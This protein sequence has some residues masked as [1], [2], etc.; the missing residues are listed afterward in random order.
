MSRS[1]QVA[2]A[3]F[4]VFRRRSGRGD[5]LRL[6][7][8]QLG[9]AW[10]KFGQ[11]L[12][13]RYDL[14]PAD[15][16][17]ALRPLQGKIAGEVGLDIRTVL[18]EKLTAAFLSIAE[19]PVAAA[20]IGQVHRAQLSDGTA[21]AV[22]VLRPS[23]GPLYAIDLQLLGRV[24]A[25]VDRITP[26]FHL[27]DMAREMST[28]VAEELDLRYEAD[29]MRR[30]RPVLKEHGLRVPKVYRGL[31]SSQVLVSQWIDG[32][33]MSDV[34]AIEDPEAWLRSQG[35]SGKKIG[36]KLL[37][38]MN[39]QIFEGNRFHGDPHPGNLM[40]WKGRIYLIDFGATSTTERA[41][42]DTFTGFVRALA[43]RDH[44]RA[45]DQYCLLC[46]WPTAPA[47]AA[48]AD[49]AQ[50]CLRRELIRVMAAWTSRAEIAALPFEDKSINRLT[51]ELMR[52]IFAAGGQ[53]NAGWL[54]ITRAMS[55]M[56]ATLGKLWPEVNYPKELRRYLRKAAAREPL[57][58]IHVASLVNTVTRLLDRAD[59]YT[60]LDGAVLRKQGITEGV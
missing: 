36:R 14:L 32:T 7:L 35:L 50:A 41:F 11:L 12:S 20:T 21:V 57:A 38:S 23:A 24:A 56:E 46:I 48:A 37:N 52:V 22:K 9:G 45:A 28:V 47:D 2:R 54:R 60:R 5:R 18:G 59:E 53:A 26:R 1:R 27:R 42:L 6:E 25:V 55:T 19:T 33:V 31:C 29:H 30:M 58:P 40:I 44:A 3:S 51:I 49:Q 8:E 39:R 4:R 13:T 34:L 10:V 17:D 15:I 43:N 16:C